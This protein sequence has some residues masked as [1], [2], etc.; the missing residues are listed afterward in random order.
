MAAQKALIK[1]VPV[2]ENKLCRKDVAKCRNTAQ[3]Q[4]LLSHG[5]CICIEIKLVNAAAYNIMADEENLPAG[6]EKRMSRSS[7]KEIPATRR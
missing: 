2:S 5:I 7:G 3:L 4:R 6:W 1:G